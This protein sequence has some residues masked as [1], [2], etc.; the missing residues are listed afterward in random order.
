VGTGQSVSHV[1]GK[2]LAY[3]QLRAEAHRRGD[4]QAI[5]EL[6]G[7]GAPPYDSTAKAVVHTRWANRYEPGMPSTASAAATVLFDS[8]V[9][10]TDI[11]N[12]MAGIRSSEDHF[13]HEVETSDLLSLG[14]DFATSSAFRRL[15]AADPDSKRWSQ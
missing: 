2:G 10:I 5:E 9:G 1:K 6:D 8:P 14:T 15:Q 11:R 4:R 12:L 3:A 7:I 13:R